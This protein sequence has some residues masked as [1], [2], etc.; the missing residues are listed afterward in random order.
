M[1][2]PR[3]VPSKISK[4]PVGRPDYI[5]S[6]LHPGRNGNTEK[7][8]A[9]EFYLIKERSSSNSNREDRMRSSTSRPYS[10]HN[11]SKEGRSSG[12][13]KQ[14]ETPYRRAKSVNMTSPFE[15][16]EEFRETPWMNSFKEESTY[17]G[18]E[19]RLHHEILAYLTY[20]QQTPDEKRAR[21]LVMTG[22]RRVVHGRFYGAEI[23]LYGSSATGLCL[24]TSDIGVAIKLPRLTEADVK[25]TRFQLSSLPANSDQRRLQVMMK[26]V[27]L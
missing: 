19:H 10:N 18:P 2:N 13:Y 9:S 22:I 1:R 11:S 20:M 4:R 5:R 12:Q 21:E 16:L 7:S 14:E 17:N 15:P 23:R 8:R 25:R 3:P 6:K 26:D 24:P 27:W